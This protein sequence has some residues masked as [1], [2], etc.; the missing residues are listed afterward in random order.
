[1]RL[2][3]DGFRVWAL[4]FMVRLGFTVLT[5]VGRVLQALMGLGFTGFGVQGFSAHVSRFKHFLACGR[6]GAKLA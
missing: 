1:M 4:W 2:R 3:L 5:R 6:L